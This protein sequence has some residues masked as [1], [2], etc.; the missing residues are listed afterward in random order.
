MAVATDMSLREALPLPRPASVLHLT[1]CE[2]GQYGRSA[3]VIETAKRIGDGVAGRGFSLSV[4]RRMHFPGAGALV[5]AADEIP[6]E[7]AALNRGL[8]RALR[9]EGFKPP[10][11]FKPHLTFGYEKSRLVPEAALLHPIKWSPETFELVSSPRGETRHDILG[12]W[13]L[14]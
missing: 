9:R 10:S 1:L 2:I 6:A 4:T 14:T 3:S 5:L 12:R 8:V 13:R 7:L 11:G